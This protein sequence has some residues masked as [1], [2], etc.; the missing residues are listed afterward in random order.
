M[1]P[2]VTLTVVDED[3]G[4]MERNLKGVLMLL[5]SYMEGISSVKSF[6]S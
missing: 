3:W 2:D 4:E 5:S 6:E 1:T